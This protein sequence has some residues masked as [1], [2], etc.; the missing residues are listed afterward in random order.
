MHTSK[1]HVLSEKYSK[2]NSYNVSKL[3]KRIITLHV[4]GATFLL[5]AMDRLDLMLRGQVMMSRGGYL[6]CIKSY[7]SSPGYGQ[8]G[9]DA[10][11][12]GYDVIVAG[13]AG[14]TH[15][16][17]PKVCRRIEYRSISIEPRCEK[18]SLRGFL[19]GLTQTGLYSHRRWLET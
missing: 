10:Q 19:P 4:S 9:P 6:L 8:T 15:I 18:T 17:G 7:I 1:I 3:N 13:T 5:Q 11:R 2:L 14:L 12:A 16:T